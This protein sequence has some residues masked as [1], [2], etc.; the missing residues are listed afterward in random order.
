MALEHEFLDAVQILID[1]SLRDNVAV[2]GRCLVTAISG[3]RC[4]I[5]YNGKT[6]NVDYFGDTPTVNKVYPLFIPYN[7]MSIAFIIS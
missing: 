4:T 2:I 7:D 6:N 5:T 3:K 1:K